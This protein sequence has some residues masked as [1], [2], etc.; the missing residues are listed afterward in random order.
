MERMQ[1]YEFSLYDK[2]KYLIDSTLIENCKDRDEA[3]SRVKRLMMWQGL[4]LSSY[5][6]TLK[7][8]NKVKEYLED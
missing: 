3:L 4:R 5:H 6:F 8:T 7:K 1:N 2:A